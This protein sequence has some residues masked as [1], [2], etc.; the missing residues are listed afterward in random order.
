MK[1]FEIWLIISLTVCYLAQTTTYMNT[2]CVIKKRTLSK[3]IYSLLNNVHLYSSSILRTHLESMESTN[4]NLPINYLLSHLQNQ[5][6]IQLQ[7]W[8]CRN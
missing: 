6:R 1:N 4:N 7:S 8:K 3:S 5:E 2:W